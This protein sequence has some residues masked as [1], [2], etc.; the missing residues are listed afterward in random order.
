MGDILQFLY[1]FRRENHEKDCQI[2]VD[3]RCFISVFGRLRRNQD[4]GRFD[5][6]FDTCIGQCRSVSCCFAF[7]FCVCFGF[8]FDVDFRCR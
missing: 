5:C 4:F 2:V 3:A 7:G 8:G 1:C 6:R